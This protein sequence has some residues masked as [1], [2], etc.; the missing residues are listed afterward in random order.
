MLTVNRLAL[1]LLVALLGACAGGDG[2]A[3]DGRQDHVWKTRT[4]ALEKARQVESLLDE[5]A[6]RQ[7][8]AQD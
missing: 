1:S 5:A 8:R 3:A 4:D 6:T 7:L 2:D